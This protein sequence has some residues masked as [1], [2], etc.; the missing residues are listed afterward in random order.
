MSFNANLRKEKSISE[1]SV[2][3]I[4][5]KPSTAQYPAIRFLV[6]TP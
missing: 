1:N 2:L 4:F 5:I 6:D 3:I